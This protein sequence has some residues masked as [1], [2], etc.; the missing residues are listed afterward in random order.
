MGMEYGL[1]GNEATMLLYGA[2]IQDFNGIQQLFAIIGH[3][4]ST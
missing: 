1:V 4:K 2:R 3:L